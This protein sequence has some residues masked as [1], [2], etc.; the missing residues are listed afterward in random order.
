MIGREG[1][2][3]RGIFVL[4]IVVFWMLL[5]M[6]WALLLMHYGAAWSLLSIPFWA[7]GIATLVSVIKMLSM[8]QSIEIEGKRLQ[9][10]KGSGKTTAH[11]ELPVSSISS[12]S[13]VEGTYKTLAGI[14]RK[15]IYPAIIANGK[16]FS[17]GERCKQEEKQWI[18]DT[19]N[20]ILG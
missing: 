16:A 20:S 12:V 10:K 11:V 14:S 5:I 8:R 4:S 15:G 2:S 19:L 17:I 13:M 3:P 9:I 7:I 18:V 1:F 6:A